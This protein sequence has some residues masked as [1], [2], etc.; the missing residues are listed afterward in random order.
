[1]DESGQYP[2][3]VWVLQGLDSTWGVSS[4]TLPTGRKE[5]AGLLFGD[6][7][8]CIGGNEEVGRPCEEPLVQDSSGG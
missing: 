4:A 7:L 8:V 2:Q 1:M 6:L 3:D 5:M